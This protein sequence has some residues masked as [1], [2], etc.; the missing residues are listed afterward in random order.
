MNKSDDIKDLL[1]ALSKA[2]GQIEGAKKDAK[3]PK[4]NS[5]YSDLAAVWSVARRP[6]YENGL[7]VS[8]WPS[9]EGD[10]VSVLTVLGHSSGQWMSDSMSMQPLRET[11]GQGFS[12]SLD[13]HTMGKTVSYVRRYSLAAVLGIYQEDDDGN[14]GS[15]VGSHR[16]A[17]HNPSRLGNQKPP[18]EKPKGESPFKAHLD[19]M[20][21]ARAHLGDEAYYE[22]LCTME[23]KNGEV[24]GYKHANQITSSE[25]QDAAYKG[26]LALAGVKNE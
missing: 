25:Q 6:L 4:F 2:Q 22:F 21:K 11:K 5:K 17:A 26:L 8:Q 19:R 14:S 12:V 23:G 13:P 15:D 7:S 3:N 20:A 1:D 24:M 18:V 10:K 9:V 16:Q